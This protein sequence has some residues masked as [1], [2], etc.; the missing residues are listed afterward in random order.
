MDD[1]KKV[2]DP[3]TSMLSEFAKL[4][5]EGKKAKAEAEAK[6]KQTFFQKYKIENTELNPFSFISELAKLKKEAKTP[7]EEIVPV[8]EEK[9]PTSSELLAELASL[10]HQGKEAN[11]EVFDEQEQHLEPFVAEV[12][13]E[14]VELQQE[15]I[16][17]ET[18]E[19]KPVDLMKWCI[20]FVPDA[21]SI[22]DPFMGSGTT[23]VAAIQMGRKFI[24]IER[25]P[26]YFDI[27]CKRIEDATR[28]GQLIPFE[29]P[30][31]E[32]AALL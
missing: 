18:E 19:Q 13:Q 28:Q 16:K 14:I 3:T 6:K 1:E 2:V 30:K 10:I 25:E 7:E 20:N 22:L 21:E 8:V 26:K 27:A 17:Q 32:Q 23:G 5:Q 12:I 4:V 9:K 11:K 29:P 31:Q 24:G 15:E